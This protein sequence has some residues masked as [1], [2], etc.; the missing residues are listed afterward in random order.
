[1]IQV[2]NHHTFLSRFRGLMFTKRLNHDEWHLFL[3]CQSVHTCFMVYELRVIGLNK[4]YGVVFNEVI[5][6][7]RVSKAICGVEHILECH[8]KVNDEDIKKAIEILRKDYK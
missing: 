4:F 7:W 8:P 5:K 6:P 3:D 2:I 1:M